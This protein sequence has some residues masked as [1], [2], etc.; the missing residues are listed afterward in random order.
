MFFMSSSNLK[1]L[2][3]YTEYNFESSILQIVF[4]I[5][6]VILGATGNGDTGP[7]SMK[8]ME[9]LPQNMPENLE[10]ILYLFLRVHNV[11]RSKTAAMSCR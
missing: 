2:W 3:P 8:G 10:T 5:S 4:Q 6:T 7:F 9:F 11:F 1:R